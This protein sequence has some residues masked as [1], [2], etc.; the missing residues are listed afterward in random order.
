MASE[1]SRFTVPITCPHCGQT[2]TMLWEEDDGHTRGAKTKRELVQVA[3]GFHAEEGRTD[4]GD[5]IIVCD[6]CDEIQDD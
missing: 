2:G 5:P 3:Q 1:R 6:A 4:S